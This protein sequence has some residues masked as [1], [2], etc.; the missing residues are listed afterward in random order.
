MA[1][2]LVPAGG[3]RGPD[4]PQARLRAPASRCSSRA[5]AAVRARARLGGA[6]R[7]P[8]AA[9]RG[10]GGDRRRLARARAA[11]VPARAA[12]VRGRHLGRDRRARRRRRARRSAACWSRPATGA[13]CSS[14]TSRSARSSTLGARRAIVE[15]RDEQAPRAARPGRRRARHR[16]ARP[17]RARH[18]R[19][20]R[21]GLDER[22]VVA[23]FA[24]AAVLLVRPPPSAAASHPRPVD[25]PRAAAP[26]ARTSATLLLGMAFFSTILA[27]IIFLTA[28]WGYSVLTAGLAVVPGAVATTIVAVPAGRLAER[29]GHR[30]VIV[31]GC[32][33]YVL[34]MAVVRGA[35]DEPDFLG[36]VAAGDDAQRRRPRPRAADARGGRADATSRRS[37]SRRASAVQAAFRQFGGVLGTAAL[38][39]V[40]APVTLAAAEDAY[41]LSTVWALGAGIVAASRSPL[42]LGAVVVTG[43]LVF[44]APAAADTN[45]VVDFETGPALNTPITTQYQ[46]S[47]FVSFSQADGYRPYRKAVGNNVVANIGADLC[48]LRGA[49]RLR[50]ADRLHQRAADADGQDG[51]AVRRTLRGRRRARHRAAARLPGRRLARRHRHGAGADDDLQHRGERDQRGRRHR[52][53]RRADGRQRRDRREARLRQPHVH[54]SR[55]RAPRPVAE[56]AVRRRRRAAG[57]FRRRPDHRH[58]AQRLGGRV[59]ARRERAAAGRHRAVRELHAAPARRGGRAAHT[60]GRRA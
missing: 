14:P 18:P 49:R 36:D 47:A 24:V 39:A 58:A 2:L 32:L 8:R 50:A 7:R 5:S 41:L 9:G 40:G 22:R 12:R 28:V 20:R 56:R 51:E 25:R 33:L 60:A 37:S 30:A 53:L 27:N 35:G 43:V 59:H 3:D 16:R 13:G 52:P 15:T 31:P 23:P 10:S 42:P 38:F 6:R 19:G 44:A 4:R 45:V 48:E 57:R 1:A 26:L 17:A 21:V 54:L 11:G 29:F 46:A 34:G 55:Q